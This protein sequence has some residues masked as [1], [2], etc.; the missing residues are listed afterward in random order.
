M[1][2]EERT[3]QEHVV[4]EGKIIRVRRDEAVLPDGRPCFREVVEH[5][6]GACVLC[7]CEGSVLLVKQFRYPY[8]ETVLEIPAGKLEAG[9]DPKAAALR[10][11]GEET[12]LVAED[13]ELLYVMYPT[14]GY[15][16]EKIYIY[17]AKR[18]TKGLRHLDEGEFLDAEFVPLEEAYA[19]LEN[20]GLHDAKTAVALLLYRT[21][22]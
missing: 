5:R 16:N 15:C 7:V 6:G 21:R 17:E 19:M 12:G 3:V 10:E 2:L 9:E 20:G 8:G 13:A 4:F 14:P 18:V 22:H 11:L 1:D